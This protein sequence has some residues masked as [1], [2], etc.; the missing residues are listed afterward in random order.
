MAKDFVNLALLGHVNHG[1]S[2]L[3][4]RLFHE[5]GQI[6]D[7][8]MARLQ[9]LADGLR[10]PDLRFAFFSDTSLEERRRG[11]SIDVAYRR[12]ET[13]NHVFNVIDVP[14]HK[15]FM[16]N[17]ISGV[18]GARAV[19]LVV[20]ARVSAEEGLAPQTREHLILLKALDLA[21]VVVVV[22]KMDA[23]TFSR[24]AFELCKLQVEDFCASLAYQGGASATYVPLSA[25]HGDNVRD[26]SPRLPWYE[27][28]PLLAALDGLRPLGDAADRPLRMTIIRT[29]SV[30]GVGSV[31]TG[32]V[33][34]GRLAPGDEIVIAPYPGSGSTRAEVKSIERQHV[35]V[36]CAGPGDDVGVLLT[37]QD[38]SFFS[39]LVKK[40]AVLGS[41]VTPPVSVNAFKAELSVVGRPSGIR[42]GYSPYLLVHQA[43]TPC[44]IREVVAGPDSG[45]LDAPATVG[46][47]ANGETGTAW[48]E[49]QRPIV[50]ERD[51][52]YP[53]LGR[54]L[55]RDGATVAIGRCLELGASAR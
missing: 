29:F 30:R 27:G 11:M 9:R 10:Q 5:C 26:A 45:G 39:R 34:S 14:G 41:A 38:K 53:R 16:R 21:P 42:A 52:D 55:I 18:W 20:D 6:P 36:A 43:S 3:V 40:G 28:P 2:T 13:P 49:T 19:V 25:T 23:V 7:R 31:V 32:I 33:E 24:D 12:L 48:I 37:K 44:R 51:C 15:D 54:F 22:N 50:V 4:G 46:E 17:A 35:Q 8:V 47:L 1:K